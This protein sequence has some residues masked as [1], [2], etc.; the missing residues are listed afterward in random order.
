MITREASLSFLNPHCPAL[1]S[2]RHGALL[3][4]MAEARPANLSIYLSIN[5]S[6]GRQGV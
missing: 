2:A 3:H 6:I 5:L 1:S 4:A